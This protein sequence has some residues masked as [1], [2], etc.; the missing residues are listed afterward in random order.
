M[1]SSKDASSSQRGA[2]KRLLET[3]AKASGAAPKD[4]K[5]EYYNMRRNARISTPVPRQGPHRTPRGS[6]GAASPSAGARAT[7]ASSAYQSSTGQPA[8]TLEMP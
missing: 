5:C 8:L 1:G 3:T 2:D 6:A 7:A 4:K